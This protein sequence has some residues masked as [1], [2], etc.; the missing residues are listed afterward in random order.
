VTRVAEGE[1]VEEVARA[2]GLSRATVYKWIA[3]YR[4]EGPSGLLDRSPS[5]LLDRSS[6][7]K[8]RPT[9]TS[10]KRTKRILK[11]RR[12]R[13][14]MREI[15]RALRM[16]VSTV[17]AVL[18]RLGWNRLPPL[19][20]PPPVRR[21]EAD[22][23][24]ELLHVDIKKLGRFKEVGHR[25]HGRRRDRSRGCGWEYVHVC[26]DSH[27]RLAYVEVLA[28]ERKETA[29]GLLERAVAWYRKQGV[30][31]ERVLTDNGSCYCS[32]LWAHTCERLEL[33]A[34]RTRPY[35]PRT[36]GKAERFVQTLS[37]SWAY[38]KACTTS[39]Y[40]R[41][42]LRPW[43]RHFNEQRPHHGIG[44]ITPLQRLRQASR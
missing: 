22:R 24:G 20:P 41:Q 14:L 44:E 3:R 30:V 15:A 23:P 25:I 8:R 35:T 33:R 9:K 39:G 2:V 40:R 38:G 12:Q 27:T 19:T 21:Y 13:W 36:N 43:L 1:P 31:S 16:A 5:G 29:A 34:S 6:A 26:V 7:P 37:R 4:S 10:S 42:G 11:W 32:K 17:A 18:K 28:D